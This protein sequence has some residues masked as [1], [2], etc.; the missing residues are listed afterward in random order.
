MTKKCLVTQGKVDL[1]KYDKLDG[2][3][4]KNGLVAPARRALV[5]AKLLRIK[6]LQKITEKQLMSLHGMGPSSLPI[7]KKEMK[8]LKIKFKD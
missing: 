7:I 6:D 8:K 1:K 3:W 2:E 5:N 4:K